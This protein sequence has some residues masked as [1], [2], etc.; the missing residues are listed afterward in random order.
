[1]GLPVRRGARTQH[2]K[3][4]KCIK[5]QRPLLGETVF[6]AVQ[7]NSARLE[8][9]GDEEEESEMSAQSCRRFPK[10]RRCKALLQRGAWSYVVARLQ[11]SWLRVEIRQQ[12][13][14]E[15][16]G[17][18]FLQALP[19]LPTSI[20][21]PLV[22]LRRLPCVPFLRRATSPFCLLQSQFSSRRGANEVLI[23]ATL[24]NGGSLEG[25]PRWWGGSRGAR[26]RFCTRSRGNKGVEAMAGSRTRRS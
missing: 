12:T 10:V 9:Q 22:T 2:D 4:E 6:T 18:P 14:P 25:A 24:A 3:L 5:L 15:R 20:S 21:I 1:M 7:F 26:T 17:T 11:T 8:E 13:R 16:R 23:G 19:P